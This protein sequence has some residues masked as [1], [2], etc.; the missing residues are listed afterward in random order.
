MPSRYTT[1]K[2]EPE[3]QTNEEEHQDE[4][5]DHDHGDDS[6][7]GNDT[8]EA[9]PLPDLED[10]SKVVLL[11]QSKEG[12]VPIRIGKQAALS[13]LFEPYKQQAVSKGWL[14]A[15]KTSAVMF[16]FDGDRLSGTETAEGLDLDNDDVIDVKW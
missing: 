7:I 13:K 16:S 15:A 6:S 14:P 3:L 5:E 12:K 11:M 1:A 2:P 10:D 8:Q 4:E 9:A